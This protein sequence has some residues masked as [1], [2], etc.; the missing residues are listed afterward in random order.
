[1]KDRFPNDDEGESGTTQRGMWGGEH[2]GLWVDDK[3]AS[4]EYD[5]ARGTIDQPLKSDREGRFNAT[6]T[7]TRES[8]GP[9][10]QG[11]KSDGHPAVYSGQV[12]G[13]VM[14]INVTLADTK[15]TVGTFELAHGRRPNLFKCK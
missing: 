7:H 11:E 2:I 4:L 14:V 12:T 6:G 15:E 13:E 3:G 5:C 9:A 10:T 1:V 8:G